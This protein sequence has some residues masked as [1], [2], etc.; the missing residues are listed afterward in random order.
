MLV[1]WQ[2]LRQGGVGCLVELAAADDVETRLHCVGALV[3][4]SST[5]ALRDQIVTDHS[6]LALDLRQCRNEETIRR[7]AVALVNLS[8]V[9]G[10]A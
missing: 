1:F 7:C 8:S 4:L 3:N 2:I 9:R 5:K 6:A 10:V